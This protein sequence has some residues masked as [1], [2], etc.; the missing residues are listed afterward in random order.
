MPPFPKWGYGDADPDEGTLEPP[1][2]DLKQILRRPLPQP[3]PKPKH[4]KKKLPAPM[5][6]PNVVDSRKLPKPLPVGRVGQIDELEN[7]YDPAS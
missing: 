6:K 5:P 7:A 1:R 3:L 2:D 4:V